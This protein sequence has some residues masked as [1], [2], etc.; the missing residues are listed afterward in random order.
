[1]E[2]MCELSTAC[3]A[4]LATARANSQS[5]IAE[6]YSRNTRHAALAIA[7]AS[8]LPTKKISTAVR[9]W[10]G[11]PAALAR[12]PGGEI[13]GCSMMNGTVSPRSEEHT[14]ELQSP[15]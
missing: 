11:T 1:M 2:R 4:K 7:I 14:S 10:F 12:N 9:V 8:A 3:S 5:A 15:M 13:N 6:L